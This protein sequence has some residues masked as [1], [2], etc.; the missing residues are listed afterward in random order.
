MQGSA[1]ECLAVGASDN[2]IALT[3]LLPHGVDKM[4]HVM[5]GLVETSCNMASFKR[6]DGAFQVRCCCQVQ[7]S[8]ASARAR[9]SRCL[10]ALH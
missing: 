9:A 10:P 5:E 2:L 6:S 1:R 7:S 8:S 3:L 4:S